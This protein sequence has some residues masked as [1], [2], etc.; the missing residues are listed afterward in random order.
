[1]GKGQNAGEQIAQMKKKRLSLSTILYH[2][3]LRIKR[4]RLHTQKLAMV[5]SLVI[6]KWRITVKI[7]CLQ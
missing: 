1:M 5:A 2:Y 7:T 4:T 3:K 6:G